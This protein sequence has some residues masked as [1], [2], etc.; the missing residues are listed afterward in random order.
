MVAE[1][2]IG[3]RRNHNFGIRPPILISAGHIIFNQHLAI[4]KH[5]SIDN[6]YVI[7][8]DPDHAFNE[9]LLG[10]ARI[11]K[12]HDVP[13]LNGLDTIDEF[14][15]ED[16]FLVVERRHH[17]GAFDFDRLIEENDD[18]GGDAE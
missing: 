6:A 4:Q 13:A 8:G 15:D 1:H 5:A 11:A 17:A 2:E 12:N 7:S 16:A 3:V 14:V 10:I 9:T 18:E